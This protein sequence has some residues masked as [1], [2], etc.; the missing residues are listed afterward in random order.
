MQLDSDVAREVQL[1]DSDIVEL[2]T[3]R[4]DSQKPFCL[5]NFHREGHKVTARPI[6]AFR[7]PIKTEPKPIVYWDL[8]KALFGEFEICQ[9]LVTRT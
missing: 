3:V 2:L 6:D 9:Q 4:E 1:S 5:I 8:R 7:S